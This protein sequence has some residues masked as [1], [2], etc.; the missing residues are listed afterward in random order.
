MTKHFV[1][2]YYPGSFFPETL[3]KQ[4]KNRKENIEAPKGCYG[5]AFFDQEVTSV[6]GEELLGK[7][8][9]HSGMTFFGKKY[10]VED[11]KREFPEN[12]TLISNVENNG[13]E[14]A[15]KT[16]RGNWQPVGKKDKVVDVP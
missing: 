9:N 8:K 1:K 10:S 7:R 14:F 11:L 3:V 4:I 2:F 13:Y 5:Y 12:K 15:V 6:K 16:I